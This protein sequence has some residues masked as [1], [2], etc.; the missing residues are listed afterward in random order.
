MK[1]LLSAVSFCILAGIDP[2]KTA[3]LPLV[4]TMVGSLGVFWWGMKGDKYDA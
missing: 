3:L 1:P 4:I 2:D